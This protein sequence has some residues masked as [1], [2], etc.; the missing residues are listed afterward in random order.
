[1]NRIVAIFLC[2]AAVFS[3]VACGNGA[4]TTES[5]SSGGDGLFPEILTDSASSETTEE[6]L[7]SD[8]DATEVNSSTDT[9]TEDSATTELPK[10]G[11]DPE[12]PHKVIMDD[13][14]TRILIAD[15]NLCGDGPEDIVIED[16][17]VW[18]WDSVHAEGAQVQGKD[19]RIDEAGLRYSSYWEKDV[20]IF[21]G[22]GGWVG[23]LDYETK[24]VLFEDNPGN[25][26][27]SVELLPNG[28]LVVACSGNGSTDQGEVLHY[29]LS[30]GKTSVGSR[31]PLKSA[32]GICWDPQNEVL[33]VLGD[34]EI[35]ACSVRNGELS[36][37]SGMGASL[38]EIGHGGGHDLVPVYGQ[39][40]KYWVSGGKGIFL[41]DS[42]TETVTANYS[43]A[44][45]Y[46]GTNVK[47]IAWFP[48]GTMIQTA[49]DQGGTG[50]YRSSLLRV[51]YLG[52]SSGRVKQV[53]VKEL[54][55][56]HREGSQ[57]YKIHT[58]SKDYQ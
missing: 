7:P 30:E 37:I 26:P 12:I 58:L 43:R 27:H 41:F 24:E 51:L 32:H 2:F 55:I 50:T 23:I 14:G 25:G 44:A 11:W 54:M 20:V 38:K 1:M 21:S 13:S 45:G 19:L 39:P 5:F 6:A 47:G 40:G 10:V 57:T 8:T 33:W 18:E 42:E 28:D 49:H 3:L 22:S 46:K 52:Y 15:L 56:P 48:D 36:V 9:D 4:E 16:C 17:I 34:T 35:I 31:V 29:P 53:T